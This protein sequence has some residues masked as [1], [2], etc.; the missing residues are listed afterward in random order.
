MLKFIVLQTTYL[1][2]NNSPGPG[3]SNELD[4]LSKTGDKQYNQNDKFTYGLK[5]TAT[6]I[7][8]EI[9]I[10]SHEKGNEAPQDKLDIGWKELPLLR[11]CTRSEC[12]TRFGG[13]DFE[14]AC[15]IVASHL[16]VYKCSLHGNG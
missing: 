5:C 4:C 10:G 3:S 16:Y 15:S 2:G 12:V 11:A 1:I 9:L 14:R 6:I 13:E 8:T 7:S